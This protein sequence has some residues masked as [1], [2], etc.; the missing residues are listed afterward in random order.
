MFK[1]I[2]INLPN[3]YYI[4]IKKPL[5]GFK[6]IIYKLNKNN[7]LKMDNK[8]FKHL[9]SFENY[10]SS[11][12]RDEMISMLVQ[13]KECEYSKTEL[14]EMSDEDLEQMSNKM[15]ELRLPFMKASKKDE[16]K[17]LKDEMEFL[18]SHKDA[19]K[20]K[21]LYREYKKDKDSSKLNKANMII[22]RYALKELDK[23]RSGASDFVKNV[24]RIID[25]RVEELGDKPIGGRGAASAST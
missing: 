13:D 7:Y 21:S 1:L 18:S 12:N 10:E 15:E 8:K 20:V 19:D 17:K 6:Y 24:Y 16:M 23:T 11:S 5:N 14:E 9:K 2:F 22:R 25:D 3:I 4:F